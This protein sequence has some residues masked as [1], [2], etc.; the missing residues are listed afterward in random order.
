MSE[1]SANCCSY[2][3][4]ET[5]ER[6]NANKSSFSVDVRICEPELSE[7]EKTS[8]HFDCSLE[9]RERSVPP[10]DLKEDL[11]LLLSLC[12]L[13]MRS[14]CKRCIVDLF[15]FCMHEKDAQKEFYG[16]LRVGR[17]PAK[18]EADK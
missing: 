14:L 8:T 9:P 15:V 17:N 4:Y 7:E 1:L 2:G 5:K 11:S 13:E 12:L 10:H 6:I 16:K 3:A 18:V